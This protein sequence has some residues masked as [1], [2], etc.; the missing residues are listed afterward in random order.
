MNREHPNEDSNKQIARL[1]IRGASGSAQA[2]LQCAYAWLSKSPQE[3]YEITGEP[4][5]WWPP[6]TQAAPA[7]QNPWQ[8]TDNTG[9]REGSEKSGPFLVSTR[10]FECHRV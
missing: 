3:I 1:G 2:F 9:V 8:V 7:D 5:E 4:T 10:G 6:D